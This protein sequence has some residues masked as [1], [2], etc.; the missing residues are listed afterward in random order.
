MCSC[1]ISIAKKVFC[2]LKSKYIKKDRGFLPEIY[3]GFLNNYAY[4][5]ESDGLLNFLLF[6]SKSFT[7]KG[8]ENMKTKKLLSLI[9][10]VIM[11]MSVVPIYASAEDQIALTEANITTY[12]TANGEI[13][14][15]QKISDGITLTGGEVQYDGAVV[16]GHF[17]F[18]DPDFVPDD[19]NDAERASIKFVPDNSEDYTGFSVSRSRNVTFTVKAVTPVFIDDND[20]PVASEVEA[21]AKLSTSEITGGAMKN[22]YVEDEPYIAEGVWEWTNRRTVVSE[23]GYYEAEFFA[24]GYEIITRK[25]Y[26]RIAGDTSESKLATTIEELPAI[27]QTLYHSDYWST[28]ELTGGKAVDSVSGVVVPGKFT[29]NTTGKMWT[30]TKSVEILFTPDSDLYSTTTGTLYVTVEP[31]PIKFVD[32][33]GNAIVPEI[34]VSYGTKATNVNV[35]RFAT[36]C[37]ETLIYDLSANEDVILA[38]GTHTL[39]VLVSPYKTIGVTPS[40]LDTVLT[41][42]VVVEPKTVPMEIKSSTDEEN[43]LVIT[44]VNYDDPS[45]QGTYD[46]YVNDELYAEN[47]PGKLTWLPEKSGEYNFRV[48]YNPIENDPCI[49]EE[50]TKQ[51]NK[52]LRRVLTRV[53]T[54]SEGSISYTYGTEVTLTENVGGNFGGWKITDANGNEVDLGVDTSGVNITF[55]MPDFNITVEAIDKSQSSND[56]AVDS[57][58]AFFQKLIDWFTNIIK[59][60]MNL[61]GL[62]A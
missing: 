50:F 40:Y 44:K 62:G 58:L 5:G 6:I 41:F 31:G 34:T 22:P 45:P 23:S 32:E 1:V 8:N 35:K 10:A 52:N 21:G 16:A 30:S 11:I 56:I 33:N 60:L 3:S 9:L 2:D 47:V 49:V 17:E 51:L 26:V 7:T 55:T 25:I 27:T 43:T 15:G 4:G 36:N 53:N 61:I 42:K 13:W 24:V 57:V 14:F 29:I 19:A 39:E 46:V 38:V 28:V 48:V 59:Q 20:L 54:L 18:I 37:S 12:P